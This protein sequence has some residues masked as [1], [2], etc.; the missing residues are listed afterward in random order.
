MDVAQLPNQQLWRMELL[1]KLQATRGDQTIS[2][3]RT[4]KTGELLAYL[5][6]HSGRS[7]ARDRLA[8]RFWPDAEP[9]SAL[10]NLRQCLTSL[11]RQFVGSEGLLQSS[12]LD[13]SLNSAAITTDV[14]EFEAAVRATYRLSG[15]DGR[16]QAER[17]RALLLYDGPFLPDCEEEWATAER[18]RLEEIFVRTALDLLPAL[19]RTMPVE[20]LRLAR[21]FV[22][23]APECQEL[24]VALLELLL[25]TGQAE[26]ARTEYRRLL[27]QFSR[28]GWA[29]PETLHA[30]FP[31]G[32]RAARSPER[33]PVP[34]PTLPY[35]RPRLTGTMTVLLIRLLNNADA[36]SEEIQD[37]V[38]EQGGTLLNPVL[39][40]GF[41]AT[42]QICALF[43]RA[44]DALSLIRAVLTEENRDSFC[45]ALH[46]AEVGSVEKDSEADGSEDAILLRTGRALLDATNAGQAFCSEVT[47]TLLRPALPNEADLQRLGRFR[48]TSGVECLYSLF[49][50]TTPPQSPRAQSDVR[51][52]LPLTLT[53]FFGRETERAAVMEALSPKRENR[54]R[55]V[56]LSGMGGC[57]KTRL[58][59]EAAQRLLPDFGNAVWFVPLRRVTEPAGVGAAIADALGLPPPV[60]P[61]IPPLK[62]VAEEL[63]AYPQSL[64]LLD[65]AEHL[66]T[67]DFALPKLVSELLAEVPTLRCLVTSRRS[68]GIAGERELPLSP[69]PLP[70]EREPDAPSIALFVDRARTV[71]PDFGITERNRESVS[72]LCRRLEGLP[73]ALEIAAARVVTRSPAVILAQ[74]DRRLDLLQRTT[75]EWHRSLRAVVLWSYELLSPELRS[76]FARLSVFRNGWEAEAARI[77]APDDWDGEETFA[78]LAELR[79]NSL[80]TVEETPYSIPE[81]DQSGLRYAMLE[82]LREYAEECLTGDERQQMA[83]RHANFYRERTRQL[84]SRAHEIPFIAPDGLLDREH[85]NLRVALDWAQ[86]SPDRAGLGL[87]IATEIATYWLARGHLAEGR[88]RLEALLGTVPSESAERRAPALVAAAYLSRDQGDSA[89]AGQCLNEAERLM[90]SLPPDHPARRDHEG[91]LRHNQGVHALDKGAWTEAEAYAARA[92]SLWEAQAHPRGIGSAKVVLGWARLGLGNHADAI[93]LGEDALTWFSR[94]NENWWIGLAHFFL[95][96]VYLFAGDHALCRQHLR[97]SLEKHRQVGSPRHIAV[98]LRDLAHVAVEEQ[99]W[100]EAT[101]YAGES[102]TLARQAGDR[103]NTA[104][105]V[106]LLAESALGTGNDRV[107]RER[108]EEALT[109]FRELGRPYGIGWGLYG[110]GKLAIR[111]GDTTRARSLLE[112]SLTLVAESH[113]EEDLAKIAALLAELPGGLPITE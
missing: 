16:Q 75:E 79:R 110:L 91:I 73:L 36:L 67:D 63:R 29:V 80:V 40:S 41:A 21:R 26:A 8:E 78:A 35:V 92:L 34:S 101:Q 97:E 62:S 5:A 43:S 28:K 82:T 71:R 57:G 10:Q 13:V 112:E 104:R 108:Y 11:R 39:Q 68:L 90:E 59:L 98:C 23:A 81:A 84:R 53:T 50:A 9:E 38:F 17:E 32:G 55:L 64:L 102:L 51:P 113:S 6:L 4:R 48:L 89:F 19:T 94:A 12:R 1:G 47:A 77:A 33:N 86:A 105:N 74:L 88:E 107:A 56:T 15:D 72:A 7:F 103:W 37:R 85:D 58:S 54:K 44:R 111:A 2:R 87:E 96:N 106:Y 42:N 83:Q 99:D 65:N 109:L 25:A 18:T 14:Q 52:S 45:A 76:F 66:L 3:F 24:Q 22:N 93:T 70:S 27:R 30:L 60:S 31:T 100:S 69:L 61:S 49:P 95:A 20:A 46:T